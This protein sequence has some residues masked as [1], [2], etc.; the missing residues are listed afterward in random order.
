MR[1]L[2]F[3]PT[4]YLFRFF[5]RSIGSFR[6]IHSYPLNFQL[7][8]KIPYHF[9]ATLKNGW[10]RGYSGVVY[11]TAGQLSRQ[12][13]F[14]RV[15]SHGSVFVYM[16]P[17]QNVMPVWVTPAWVHPDCCTGARISPQ[18]KILQQYHVHMKQP[19]ISVWNQSAGRLEWVAH[20]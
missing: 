17:P 6:S 20:A 5:L 9:N 19:L 14:T 12:C 15:P 4:D 13:K 10:I 7:K 2:R 11:M 16:I 3:T 8:C 1:N 18:Y